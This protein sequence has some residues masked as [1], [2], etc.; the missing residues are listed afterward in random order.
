MWLTETAPK[1]GQS[2][3]RDFVSPELNFYEKPE[4]LSLQTVPL[5][6]SACVKQLNLE[7][8]ESQ[9]R[10]HQLGATGV[11][12]T[13]HLL[14]EEAKPACDSEGNGVSGVLATLTYLKHMNTHLS[15]FAPAREIVP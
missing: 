3:Q 11:E 9:S 10:E 6:R 5:P 13:Q 2:Y 14:F 4:V 8:H 7:V 1:L 12:N 15:S